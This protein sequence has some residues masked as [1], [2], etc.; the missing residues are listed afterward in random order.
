[1]P[2]QFLSP[3]NDLIFKLLFG[4]E[5]SK[6]I[7]TDFLKSV[8]LIPHEDY[9]TITILD[10]HLLPDYKD[11]KLGIIDVK[12]QTKSGKIINIEIQVEH[13]PQ[14]RERVIFYDAKMVTEQIGASENYEKIKKVI[15]IIITNHE[16]IE[17]SP[18]Y[19]HRFTLY[20]ADNKV[21]FTD[22]IEIH[23]LELPKIP[24]DSDGTPLWDWMKFLDA[25]NEEDLDM[26]AV[27]NTQVNNAVIRLKELSA[28]ERTR[29]LYES[30][31]KMERDIY[32]ITKGKEDAAEK[33]GMERGMER[34]L[35]QGRN[36]G[37]QQG[38]NEG[39][40]QGM[41]AG[42]IAIAQNLLAMNIPIDKIA[43]ATKLTPEEIEQLRSE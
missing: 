36:E 35:H 20:D 24:S 33:R 40:Q 1:M 19:H 38:R 42:K 28:D 27:A 11:G 14:M 32:S 12:L 22:T 29:M 34:G 41:T 13:I 39:I 5:R 9:D 4:D 37:L 31:I 17:K 6:E 18:K 26:A 21:E 7:L 16:F 3:R 23:T 15:S 8:L 30:R 10:P 43:I 25:K 2:K